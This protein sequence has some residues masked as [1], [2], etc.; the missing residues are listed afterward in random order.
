MGML[1]SGMAQVALLEPRCQMTS[2]APTRWLRRGLQLPVVVAAAAVTCHQ[3]RHR[4]RTRRVLLALR[5]ATAI[6]LRAA[7]APLGVR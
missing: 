3:R 6:P 5:Q 7:A 1:L 2:P 4:V